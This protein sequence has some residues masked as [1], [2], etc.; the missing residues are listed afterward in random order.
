MGRENEKKRNKTGQKW[1]TGRVKNII[2]NPKKSIELFHEINPKL[3]MD[4]SRGEKG[5]WGLEIGSLGETRDW[6]SRDVYSSTDVY[7]RH[8]ANYMY[9]VTILEHLWRNTSGHDD[10]WWWVL[11]G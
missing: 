5:K 2:R 10:D 8:S 11:S 4:R 1:K 9:G 6:C 7:M 3:C